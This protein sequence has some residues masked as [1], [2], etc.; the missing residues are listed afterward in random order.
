MSFLETVERARILLERN[1]RISMRALKLEFG[2]DDDLLRSLVD[3][4]VDVERVASREGDTVVWSSAATLR[5]PDSELEAPQAAAAE[6]P[7]PIFTEGERRQVAIV[8]ADLAGST[9]ISQSLDP[10]ALREVVRAYQ[11]IASRIV[12]RYGGHIAQY[13]GDGILVYFGYPVSHEDDAYRAV[14]SALEIP[15]A[16][17]EVN[18]RLVRNYGVTLDVRLGVHVG[19]V[20]VGEMGG[21]EHRERL[22]VGDAPNIAA[23]LQAIAQP[24][25]V[26]ISEVTLRLV[27]GLFV[28]EDLGYT[29]LKGVREP[30][31]IY[32]VVQ[33][34]G[35]PGRVRDSSRL[36]PFVGRE[37][38]LEFLLDRW[39]AVE[40]GEGQVALISGD[41]GVGKTRMI[42]A[43]RDRLSERPHSWLEC[44]ATEIA[45]KTAFHPLVELIQ[46]GLG[47]EEKDTSETRLRRLEIGVEITGL[48]TTTLVPLLAPLLSL[49]VPET[50]STPVM[51]PELRRKQTIEALATVFI[52]L[53]ERQ[54]VVLLIDDLHWADPSTLETL[55]FLIQ[56]IPT[57]RLLL[58]VTCRPDFKP[59]WPPRSYAFFIA[60]G[61]LRRRQV[62]RMLDGM[63]GGR[64]FPE[65][66]V[67]RI[68]ERSA[69]IPLFVE[70]L[71]R[72]VLESG[73]LVEK[74]QRYELMREIDELA[75]P[76]TLQS[77]LMARLDRLGDAKEIAQLCATV[78]MEFDFALLAAVAEVD[79]ATLQR[80]LSRLV[81]AELLFQRGVVPE[82]SFAFRHNLIQVTAYK[83]LLRSVRSR[84]HQRIATVIEERFPERSRAEP[85][86]LA[87]HWEKTDQVARSAAY[88]RLAAERAEARSA[89]EEALW[90][91]SRGLTLI[92]TLPASRD[93]NRIELELRLAL[94]GVQV[95]ALGYAHDEVQQ[96][97]SRVRELTQG[98][99]DTPQYPQALIAMSSFHSS[100]AEYDTAIEV[101]RRT[102]EH[103]RESAD[104]ALELGGQSLLGIPTLHRDGP[105]PALPLLESA[106]R[107][108]YDPRRF[109]WVSQIFGYDLGVLAHGYAAVALW[110]LGFPDR[111]LRFAERGM[112]IANTSG[113]ALSI[114]LAIAFVAWMRRLRGENDHAME[115]AKQVIELAERQRSA[116]YVAHGKLWCA[117]ALA[118]TDAARAATLMSEALAE[119]A[120][121]GFRMGS[122]NRSRLAAI[123]YRAAGRLD[124]ARAALNQAFESAESTGEK[125]WL[126]ESHLL[127]G[128]L[129][130]EGAQAAREF[131][132][133]LE[134]ARAQHATSL[135][136]RAAT[137]LAA[138][139]DRDGQSRQAKDLLAPV[140]ASFTEGLDT[141]DLRKARELL[142]QLES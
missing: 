88:R 132:I 72:A 74:E 99:L 109:H 19:A 26:V 27:P 16:L 25:E 82:A 30:L 106:I 127:R 78:G 50:Y 8:F 2:L 1:K 35:I 17:G 62:A 14:R 44:T 112:Q 114:P 96:T 12:A 23:R 116:F 43:L 133:A 69:G 126:S 73:V 95:A 36:T 58:L 41:A 21:G 98:L 57:T 108:D 48:S 113:H 63:T 101:G 118:E 71:A 89:H 70:E 123:V 92:E 61:G 67:N 121:V 49:P 103:A 83:S 119:K 91:L 81:E 3:E 15:K 80:G 37:Q 42:N 134:I 86:I 65:D 104:K 38:E 131:Q 7:Q 40:E 54:P 122:P 66:V 59:P 94:V 13:M 120:L 117:L 18:D 137:R 90:H 141:S 125:L 105:Y 51:T 85:E 111:A 107:D 52:G 124:E 53:A 47:L 39:V 11:D 129:Q 9:R 142:L 33:P 138:L 93:R 22:A 5:E 60:L 20:V 4:L 128:E 136:L 139:W 45:A 130:T 55:G 56:Q 68:F 64:P 28:T 87:G 79:Q 34:S 140:F 110:Q 24:G 29:E 102:I 135:E 115:Y 6:Q 32:R 97:L 77:L 46:E 76:A 31:R 84:L 10:E 75:I 100:R